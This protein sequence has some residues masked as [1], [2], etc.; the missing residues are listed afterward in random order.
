[1][2]EVRTRTRKEKSAG[3]CCERCGKEVVYQMTVIDTYSL[4]GKADYWRKIPRRIKMCNECCKELSDLVEKF[5]LKPGIM[6]KLY[7]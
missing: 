7:S 1:M 3:E 6:E 2:D 5:M 4:T